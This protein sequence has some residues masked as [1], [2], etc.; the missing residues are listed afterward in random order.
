[1]DPFEHRS[2]VLHAGGVS[3]ERIAAEHGTPCYVYSRA[4]LE[5]HW[6]AF[7][8][9]LAERD[10]LVCYAVKANGNLAVLDVLARLG[11]GFDIV[12]GGELERVIAAGGD[13]GRVV[14][15]GVA[16]SAGEIRRALDAR[17]LSFNVESERELELLDS[18][19]G[20]AG[21]R[22]PVSLRVNPDVNPQTHPYIATG[23]R[24]T[25][26]GVP[27]ET[28]PAL[29]ERAAGMAHL[30][31]IG[32]DCHIGSQLVSIAPYVDAFERVLAL[33][34]ELAAAGIRIHHVNAGGGLGIR[35]RDEAPP[36]PAELARALLARTGAREIAL[37]VEPGRAIAGNAG[38]LVTRV[39]DVKRS[40]SKR[41]AIVD[42][43]MNDLIRPVLYGAWMEIV[44]VAA[45][46]AADGAG[47]AGGGDRAAPEPTDVVG[48][49]CESGDFLA[50]DR[51]LSVAPGDLLAV[52]GA[53]AYGFAMSSNYN[54]RP[55]APELLVDG[56]RVH[57]AR[58]RE[59]VHDLFALEA[60]LP[61][62]PGAGAAR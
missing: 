31:V 9:A 58:M 49:V 12:S 6:R 18:L 50:R 33:V 34:D 29:Y 17:I 61:D 36:A 21:V 47:A 44:P 30:E 28:A 40:G 60:M 3:I 51:M 5:H 41:F 25:K 11:S 54:S 57:V 43:A 13:P 38:V 52:R 56:A 46:H 53:G 23:L 32:V 39:V 62:A 27:I 22:A 45:A 4:A 48:P 10:H 59:S 19:A 8:D 2:G 7:D 20:K 15:S 16:K 35:Y 24:E 1:M 37:L 26:F 55:R 42:A 14:F